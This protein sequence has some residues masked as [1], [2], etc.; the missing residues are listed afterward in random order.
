MG[1][2]SLLE[3]QGAECLL[4]WLN[5]SDRPSQCNGARGLCQ[6]WFIA[7]LPK[8]PL[9]PSTVPLLEVCEVPVG[10]TSLQPLPP[11]TKHQTILKWPI[12]NVIV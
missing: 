12:I 6:P 5:R 3:G 4:V 10:I 1:W 2:V 9:R 11:E 8:H 7:G